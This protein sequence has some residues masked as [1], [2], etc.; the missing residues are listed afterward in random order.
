MKVVAGLAIRNRFWLGMTIRVS[1][2][3]LQLVEP[4][5][6]GLGAAPAL[7]GERLG[8][9][10]DGQ[11][12]LVARGLGD[13]RRGAGAGAAAEPGGDEAHMGAVE[14]LLDLGERFLGRGLAQL[15]ARSG[16]QPLGG[17]AAELHDPLGRRGLQR[18]GVGIGG[19]EGHALDVARHHVGDRIAAGA[20]DADHADSR[21]Q[22]VQPA[23]DFD[24]VSP[25]PARPDKTG[26]PSPVV[27][28]MDRQR[29]ARHVVEI[30]RGNP[31]SPR[32]TK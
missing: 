29:P 6:G 26:A 10:A 1:T 23:F 13:H 15:G 4:A 19:D 8:D 22:L 25:P 20:A 11:D 21:A 18:L 27:N 31:N 12:A 9:H 3:L 16:A 30:L 7:E 2:W 17:A 32:G 5:L 28:H 24:H 14:H